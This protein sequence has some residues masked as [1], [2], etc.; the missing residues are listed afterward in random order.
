MANE[1]HLKK[2]M[3]AI[4]K[5]DIEIWNRWQKDHFNISIDIVR[6]NRMGAELD[7]SPAKLNCP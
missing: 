5:K 1:E 6:T 7:Q 4:E 2:L 3:E